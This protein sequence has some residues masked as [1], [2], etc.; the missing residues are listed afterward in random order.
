MAKVLFKTNINHLRKVA[1][2]L[3]YSQTMTFTQVILGKKNEAKRYRAEQH[4]YK[5]IKL[6]NE[7]Q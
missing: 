3:A 5:A 7:I 6:L 2:R 4:I 1:S